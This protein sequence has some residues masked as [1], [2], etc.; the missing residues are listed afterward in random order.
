MTP[1]WYVAKYV[2]DIRR[3]EPRNIGVLVLDR[4]GRAAARFYGERDGRPIDG[5]TTRGVVNS[6]E[7][8]RR[9]V[10]HWRSLLA[11]GEPALRAGGER[12]VDD[13]YYL[14]PGGQILLASS[15]RE[16]ST[17]YDL[18]DELYTSIVDDIPDAANEDVG[19]LSERVIGKLPSSIA[20]HV[21]RETVVTVRRDDVVDE[22]WF[23]YRYDNGAAHL[24][25]RVGLTYGDQRS[26]DRVH[27][28]A[29]SFD[30]VRKAEDQEVRDARCIALVKPRE[31]DQALVSQLRS[32]EQLADVVDV[33]KQ[34]EA[35]ARLMTLLAR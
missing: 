14:E 12:R 26:W 17:L 22:L 30:R 24:M 27:A 33:T 31:R 9:W 29:W 1:Q 19:R 35:A 11:G 25:Q 2:P 21:M 6:V 20:A 28:A 7:V 5:R 3:G 10:A 23:D 4:E 13:N 8:Y 32:L 34:D 18:L 15:G 16:D